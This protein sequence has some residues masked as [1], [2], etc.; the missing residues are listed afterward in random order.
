MFSESLTRPAPAFT[1]RRAVVRISASAEAARLA[2]KEGCFRMGNSPA[3]LIDITANGACLLTQRPVELGQM[4]WLGVA[5]LPCEWVKATVRAATFDGSQWRC[6][7]AFSE[8][9]PVG[10]LE[11]AT[12]PRHGARDEPLP[13]SLPDEDEG[14]LDLAGWLLDRNPWSRRGRPHSQSS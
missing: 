5:S 8:P 7:L 1:E 11:E 2:W 9:C 4:L 12:D 6:H 3:R 13:Q 10:L 14:D